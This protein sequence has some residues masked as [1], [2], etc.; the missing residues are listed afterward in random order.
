M[1]SIRPFATRPAVADR[2]S[3]VAILRD[4]L[5]KA[6]ADV[7]RL[8]T[9][10]QGAEAGEAHYQRL[11]RSMLMAYADVARERDQARLLVQA[12]GEQAPCWESGPSTPGGAS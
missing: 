5:A 1:A 11:Y 4:E 12:M 6:Q 8:L 2:G 3:E 9:R 7:A 10:V